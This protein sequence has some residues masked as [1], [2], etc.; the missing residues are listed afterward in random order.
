MK[1][2]QKQRDTSFRKVIIFDTFPYRTTR[3][4]HYL[5][6]EQIPQNILCTKFGADN[7]AEFRKNRIKK[8]LVSVYKQ[9]SFATPLME[10]GKKIH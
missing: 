4:A 5:F 2:A 8:A 7:E 6:E 3:T 10:F 1:T 9:H